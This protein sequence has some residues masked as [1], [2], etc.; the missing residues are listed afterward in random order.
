MKE[1]YGEGIANHT[2]PESCA[3]V[4]EDGGE[5]LTRVRTGWVW[6]RERGVTPERRRCRGWRKATSVVSSCETRQSSARSE[7][8]SMYGNTS[9]GNRESPLLFGESDRTALGS[10]RTNAGDAR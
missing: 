1:S 9:S 6:S 7:A 4:R 10:L 5:A 8:P 2:G 3:V